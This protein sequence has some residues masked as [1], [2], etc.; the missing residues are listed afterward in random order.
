MPIYQQLDPKLF[1]RISQIQNNMKL[2]IFVK[3]IIHNEYQFL[4]DFYL[5]NPFYVAVNDYKAMDNH[6]LI[7]F[8][9]NQNCLK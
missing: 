9:Q 2:H 5:I 3:H 8:P 7:S 1:F 6:F 4:L